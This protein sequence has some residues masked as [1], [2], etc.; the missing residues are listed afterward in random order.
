MQVTVSDFEN[1][2]VQFFQEVIATFQD[3]SMK[4]LGGAALAM[5]A[6]KLDSLIKSQA[7]SNGMIDLDNMKTIVNAG[8]N[9]SGGELKIPIGE[10]LSLLGV[11]PVILKISQADAD[12]F[13]AQF[14]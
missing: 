2:L 10:G 6:G 13:F 7:D 11:R 4:F 8:F 14:V 12:K 5:N 9:S 1:H 3:T